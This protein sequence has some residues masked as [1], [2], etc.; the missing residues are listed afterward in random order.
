MRRLA[1]ELRTLRQTA[2][3]TREAVADRTD[4]NSATLWRIET[5]RARPQRRTL[6]T[7][8]DLYGVQDERRRAELIDL[9]RP[10]APPTDRSFLTDVGPLDGRSALL[11]RD[12]TLRHYESEAHRVRLYEWRFVPDLLQTERYAHAVLAGS[13]P[14]A[15]PD[16]IDRLATVRA[17]R[18]ARLGADPPI[19][20]HALLDES[21]LHRRVGDDRTHRTQLRKLSEL[22]G[23][24]GITI[25]VLPYTLGAH[26][27]LRSAF[28]I[29]DFPDPADAGL[30]CVETCPGPAFL[31][32]PTEFADHV[33]RFE[34]LCAAAL[35]PDRSRS[36]V[37]GLVTAGGRPGPG[38]R[39]TAA[40]S[41]SEQSR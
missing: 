21:A 8:M 5:G 17:H 40:D 22:A 3:L 16:E 23:A 20:V 24:P 10:E 30:V 37:S 29:V 28:A 18:R 14:D 11:H 9:T 15:G 4:L 36:L 12:S 19:E 6:L 32:D 26:V 41:P 34:R 39:D 7:L 35:D 38:S 27:G 13:H 31:E 33:T 1:T 25:Q 2:R